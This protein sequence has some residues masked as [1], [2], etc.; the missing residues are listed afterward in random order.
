MAK[1]KVMAPNGTHV[2]VSPWGKPSDM[3]FKQGELMGDDKLADQYPTI[4]VKISEGVTTKKP[5]ALK[6][7]PPT[8]VLEEAP[9][10]EPEIKEAPVKVSKKS[11]K[12]K[13]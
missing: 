5:V 7:V 6:E 3:T 13:K 12:N 2:T 11:K 1:Y 4:F 10:A 8:E 9:V